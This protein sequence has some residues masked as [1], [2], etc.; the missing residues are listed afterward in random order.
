MRYLKL[1]MKAEVAEIIGT[2]TI[3]MSKYKNMAEDILSRDYVQCI[4][5]PVEIR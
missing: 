3:G 4:M 5:E 2:E 1:S